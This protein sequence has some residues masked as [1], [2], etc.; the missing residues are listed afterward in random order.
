M[1]YNVIES[2]HSDRYAGLDEIVVPDAEMFIKD[3]RLGSGDILIVW[4]DEA[5]VYDVVERVGESVRA[6][7]LPIVV[8]GV[9]WTRFGMAE[10]FTM[11]LDVRGVPDLA[12]GQTVWL[13]G[14]TDPELFTILAVDREN[15]LVR[16]RSLKP[17]R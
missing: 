17:G 14:D 2:A 1:A 5:I 16:V 10:E 6:T 13:Y 3:E 9:D 12:V 7:R 15:R 4:D 11:R 8:L